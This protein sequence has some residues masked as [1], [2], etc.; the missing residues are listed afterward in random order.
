LVNGPGGGDFLPAN[1]KGRLSKMKFFSLI[2]ALLMAASVCKADF[3]DK[4][5]SAQVVDQAGQ[6]VITGVYTFVYT[7]G[8]KTLATLYSNKKRAS[9]ANPLTRASFATN[10]QI[11]FYVGAS[12]VDLVLAGS[13]GSI[14]KYSSVAQSTHKL[15]LNSAGVDK[16]MIAPFSYEA[17]ETDTG[18]DFPY[19]SWIKDVAV[20]VVTADATETID[21]GL[22]STETSGDADGLL[23]TVPLDSTGFVKGAT[24]QTGGSETYVKTM[25]Y[26]V[27]MG[28]GVVGTD[29]ASDFGL[30]PV[31][32]H[33]VTGAN[34]KSLTYTCSSGSDTAAGYIYAYFRALR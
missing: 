16:V 11:Q 17:A 30:V 24:T 10:G 18:L 12:T 7:A 14:A 19:G 26:G 5:F 2:A 6:P 8:S 34:A 20:E 28:A 31:S 32:G 15:V 9:L 3:R 1:L 29:S 22:L 4:Y 33:I 21:V 23:A 25:L 13:D 27:L